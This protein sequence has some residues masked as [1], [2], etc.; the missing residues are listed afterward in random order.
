MEILDKKYRKRKSYFYQMINAKQLEKEVTQDE[1]IGEKE[2]RFEK[3]FSKII[4]TK[5]AL[6]FGSGNH[7]LDIGLNA[8]DLKKEDEVLTQ[9][10][11]CKQVPK[12]ISQKATTKLVD[13]DDNYNIDLNKAN[14]SCG[15]KTRAVQAIYSYGKAINSKELEEFCKKNDLSLIEDCAHSLGA[16][17]GKK[18]GSFGKFS[19]FSL[20]K[21]IPVGNGGVLCTNDKDI[22]TKCV[23]DRDSF[24]QGNSITKKIIEMKISFWKNYFPTLDFPYILWSKLGYGGETMNQERLDKFEISLAL[25][26]IK[27]LPKI[28]EQTRKNAL[29]LKK[30]LGEDKFVFTKDAKKEINVATRVPIY[31]K[32]PV[33][34][35][36]TIWSK[37][38]TEGF[39]TGLFYTTDFKKTVRNAHTKFSVSKRVSEHMIPI[40]VQ[41]LEKDQVLELAKRIKSF[42]K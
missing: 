27:Q 40:G 16:K 20:R 34:K 3:R 42:S 5:Y 17:N 14:N 19:I 6:L 37:L 12:T 10:F 4:G 33:E 11:T 26:S 23:E 18:A 28:I 35:V 22:Y 9:A 41:G 13:I 24:G 29:L 32:N 21:N 31:F 15:K 8:L 39:E 30:E 1:T 38:Q 36:E 7:A 2:L 25:S